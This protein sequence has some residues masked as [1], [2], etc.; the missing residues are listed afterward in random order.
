MHLGLI[1]LGLLGRAIARRLMDAGHT[2]TGYDISDSA[3]A[4][5][6]ELGVAVAVNADAAVADCSHVILSLLT[7]EDRRQLLWGE[8]NLSRALAQ[9][10]VLLDTTTARPQDIREDHARLNGESG[11]RLIDVCISGS[12]QVVAE[13]RALALIGDEEDRAGYLDLLR[14]FTA[15]QYFFGKPG[16]G[17]EAKLIVNLVFGLNR[18][19][20]AEALGLARGAGFDLDSIL[21]ILRNGETYSTVMDTKGPKMV[22]GDYEPPVARLGQHAK[23]VQ[24]ILEYARGLH[25]KVPL[26]EV[27]AAILD[28]LIELGYGDLDNAAVFKAY[29]QQ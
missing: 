4:A 1:G 12:S 15:Q 21:D 3:C 2:V 16:D 23:D 29:D 25:A 7:S 8:Q 9:G 20:L 27:H 6:R 5:A 24:L 26:T 11:A 22:A 17:N 14:T 28:R 13:G 18:L 19:V 10:M